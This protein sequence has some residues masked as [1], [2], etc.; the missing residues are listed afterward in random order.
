MSG[1]G[2]DR[3]D[4]CA[5]NYFGSPEFLGGECVACNCS[6]NWQESLPGM[7]LFEYM[8]YTECPPKVTANLYC[9]CLSIY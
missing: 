4:I 5:D 9:I 3:C 8:V 6:G 1:Y 2:G 7:W